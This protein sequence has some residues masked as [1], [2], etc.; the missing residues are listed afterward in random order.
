MDLRIVDSGSR[1]FG[2]GGEF[3]RRDIHLERPK[4]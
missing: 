1:S 4:N 2:V 3:L